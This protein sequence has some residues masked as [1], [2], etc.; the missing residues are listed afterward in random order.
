MKKITSRSGWLLVSGLSLGL[1]TAAGAAEY[2]AFWVDAWGAGF[3]NQNQITNLLGV[4]GDA[5]S[6]GAIRDANC[7]SVIVQV[8]R[9][10]DVCYPSAMGEPYMSGLSPANFNALQAMIDAAH[11]TTGGKKRI[12]VHCWLVTFATA[13]SSGTSSVYYAHCHPPTGSLTNFDNYWPTRNDSGGETDDKA[14]D[15]GHPLVLQYLV[16][17]CMDLVTNFDIDGIHYDYIRFTANNQGYNPTSIARYNARYGLTGQ[18]AAADEQFKQWRRDQVS[19]L[20]RQVYAK[21]QKYKPSVKHSG[22]FVTWNPSPTNSTRQAF[23]GT[24]PYYDVY[25]DWDSWMQE[26]IMD[27]AVPMTYYDWASLPT[28][29][30]KWM[31]FEKDRKF[32]RHMII[33]PGTYLNYLDDAI[34]ELQKTRD[35]SPAGNCA[36][37]FSGYSY[38]SP[39]S[40]TKTPTRTYGTWANF[41]ARLVPDVTP[42]WEDI[43]AMPWKTNPT[44]AH[45]M[46]VVT[47]AGSG[48]WADGATV[49]V[50]NASTNRS[51]S[52]DGTGFYAFIDLPP[53]GYTLTASKAGYLNT[54]VATN[55]VV[56]AVTGNMYE[57]DFVLA[58][59]G[60]PVISAEPEDKSVYQGAPAAFSVGVSGT[61]PL[62][63]QW[64]HA[65]T[66]LPGATTSALSIAAATTNDAG[67]YQVIITNTLGSATSRVA[68]LTVTVP[69]TNT[70]TVPLWNLAPGSRTYIT[71]G[72]T[73]R[74]L[75]YNP[76]SNRLL[77]VSRAGTAQIYVLDA[78]TGAELH[79]LSQGSG[80]ISGGYFTML[81]IS[82]ADDGALYLGN[83]RL[84]GSSDNFR[85]YRWADD[86]PGTLPV[87]AYSGSPMSSSAQRWGDTMDTRGAGTGTQI[88]IG[89]RTNNS[90]VVFTTADGT[91]FTAN[92]ITVTNAPN[93]AFGLGITFGQGNTFW[94]KSTSHPLRKV[95][96]DLA[97][98]TGAVIQT[99]SDPEVANAVTAIGYSTN[100]ALVAGVAIETPDNLKLYDLGTNSISLVETNPFPA[101][102]T[103]SNLTGA[104]DFSP[105]RVFA[106]DSGNGILARRILP[107]AVAPSIQTPP[108]DCTVIR[109]QDAVFSVAASG[110][111][112]LSY[113]WLFEGAEIGGAVST[114]YT[115]TNAQ[116]S[117]AG[118]YRVVVTNA[119]GATTSAVARL[120]VN[121]PPEIIAGLDG[122]TVVAGDDVSFIIAASGTAPLGYQWRFHGT[123]LPGETNNVLSR[124]LVQRSDAGP[125]SIVVSNVA[126]TNVSADAVLAV[127][128]PASPHIG[129][130]SAVP[131]GIQLQV[132]GVRGRYAMDFSTNLLHWDTLTNFIHTNASFLWVDPRTNIPIRFYRSHIDW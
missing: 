36:H 53:G 9:R 23:Q 40:L 69:A 92:P 124:S 102:N 33:G 127:T 42:A 2:R 8:R 20:V 115:R 26:G 46:G 57:Q 51:L 132:D 41:A 49:T 52:V 123:N 31:N 110:S 3:L 47:L 34:L 108:A 45:I 67:S 70:R 85:L 129:G 75:A 43:P 14:F 128:A 77:L 94:G 37:G 44:T 64:S 59:A 111:E 82:A 71:S 62:V 81:L 113:Q 29:Y 112:P 96:F 27:I 126:G 76:I 99:F 61:E 98:G 87:V 22:S 50:T 7:N 17:V 66:N 93:G 32:N 100:L 35:A 5:N 107:L 13:S 56:G 120:T 106:L 109:G 95:Q 117:H 54:S 78:D 65:G 116:P 28:D 1:I 90:V 4:V 84:N 48:Y 114:N 39:Y 122:Q 119:A 74:G 24:R 10:Y 19:A 60:K 73:E 38:R 6:K 30:T 68:T 25:S 21:I 12:D 131:S 118:E 88:I 121:V 63:F 79:T 72:T 18:P 55:I 103:N 97:T 15:P 89:S 130:I 104:V 91:N 80:I 58:L 105:D 16:N 11:D 86:A 83:L 125:Y 101:D